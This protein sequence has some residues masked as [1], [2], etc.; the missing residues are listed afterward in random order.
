MFLL[1]CKAIH[2]Q[3]YE[4]I[5]NK[6]FGLQDLVDRIEKVF[7]PSLIA[8]NQRYYILLIAELLCLYDNYIKYD[9]S[10]KTPLLTKHSDTDEY[11][12]NVNFNRFNPEDKNKI[13]LNIEAFYNKWEQRD[14]SIESLLKGINLTEA[15]KIEK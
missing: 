5:K 4:G 1:Y 2:N 3:I 11:K 6:S 9:F 14:D 8:E 15:F 12:L 13:K 7:S 10:K